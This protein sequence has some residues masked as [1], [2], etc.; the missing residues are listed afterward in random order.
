MWSS[1]RSCRVRLLPASGCF[2]LRS[3]LEASRED[4]IDCSALL[5]LH[6]TTES[7]EH[8]VSATPN[9][10]RHLHGVLVGAAF[11]TFLRAHESPSSDDW[12]ETEEILDLVRDSVPELGVTFS[13]VRGHDDIDP[14][15]E[16]REP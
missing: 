8:L 7:L 10:D 5:Q 11:A 3:G 16:S 4:V 2:S 1:L 6:V 14:S 9:R 15:D 12:V 13:G